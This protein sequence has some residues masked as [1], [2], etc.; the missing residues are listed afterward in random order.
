MGLTSITRRRTTRNWLESARE[1]IAEREKLKEKGVEL[2]DSLQDM[3]T[4]WKQHLVGNADILGRSLG[5]LSHSP[6]DSSSGGLR[7]MS[8]PGR[9]VTEPQTVTETAVNLQG[10]LEQKGDELTL[11]KA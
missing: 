3:Q 11:L 6:S 2:E 10:K 1:L 8:P 5:R 9:G 4:Q 7:S